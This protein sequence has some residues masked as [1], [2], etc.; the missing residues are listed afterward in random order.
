MEVEDAGETEG[1]GIRNLLAGWNV[2]IY[3]HAQSLR[4]HPGEPILTIVISV[5]AVS[6][7]K[8]YTFFTISALIQKNHDLTCT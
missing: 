5:T 1:S 7:G 8:C 6:I 4:D 2:R 3:F